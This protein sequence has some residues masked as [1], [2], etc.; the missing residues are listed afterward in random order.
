[1][2][3]HVGANGECKVG[4]FGLATSSLAAVDPLDLTRHSIYP[5]TDMTLSTC[6]CISLSGVLSINSQF[7]GR[8]KAVYRAC[9]PIEKERAEKP[10]QG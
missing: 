8:R 10:F 9:G 7:R 6:F 4:N 1:M 5:E 2:A 3:R